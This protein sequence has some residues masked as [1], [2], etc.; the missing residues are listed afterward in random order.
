MCNENQHISGFR[1]KNLMCRLCIYLHRNRYT[2]TKD[3]FEE[4]AERIYIKLWKN[5]KSGECANEL[6][7][8]F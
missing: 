4:Y 8:I 2:H 7:I 1:F 3:R 5:E 6:I